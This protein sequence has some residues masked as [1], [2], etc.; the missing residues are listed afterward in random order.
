ML[1]AQGTN[2]P[3][4]KPAESEQIVAA[5]KAAGID[6]EYLLF[7]DEGHGFY[8]PENRLRFFGT[9]EKFLARHLGGRAEG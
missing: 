4:V 1:I 7:P 2:D 6:H 5:L 9:A 3:R 8:M